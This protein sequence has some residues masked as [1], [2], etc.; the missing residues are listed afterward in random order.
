[1]PQIKHLLDH[2]R[3]HADS[4]HRDMRLARVAEQ[5]PYWVADDLA[6]EAR[7]RA[8]AVAALEFLQQHAGGDSVWARRAASMYETGGPSEAMRARGVGDLLREWADQVDAGVVEVVG[9]RA[10]A[11]VDVVSTDIMKQVRRLLEDPAVH[12][13]APIV[14]CGAALET[15]L[16][17]LAGARNVPAPPRPGMKALTDALRAAQLL[18]VQDVKD[19]DAAAGLRNQAAHGQFQD[20]SG[21]RAGLME[22]QTNL[23]L[24]RTSDLM[25]R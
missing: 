22:Q 15:A 2:A 14:L 3:R 21:Q 13:A 23:L 24:R 8:R 6:A 20:L 12:P 11:Q 7:I 25:D 19:I 1:M 17:A 16:R 9:A 5:D 18:T 10:W 4:L